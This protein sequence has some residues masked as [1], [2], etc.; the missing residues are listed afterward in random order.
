MT[1]WRECAYCG[2]TTRERVC[3]P[4]CEYLAQG[5][6]DIEV[7]GFRRPGKSG[8]FVSDWEMAEREIRVGIAARMVKAG[9]PPDIAIDEAGFSSDESA[10]AYRALRRRGLKWPHQQ[11]G[12]KV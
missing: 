8:C 11:N 3:S 2:A 7:R 5:L 6:R 10:S 4:R 12:L 9:C 1:P